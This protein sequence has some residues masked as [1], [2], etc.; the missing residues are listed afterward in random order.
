MLLSNRISAVALL[1]IGLMV[2]SSAGAASISATSNLA[3]NTL[4]A[5]T[6]T[7]HVDVTG[8]SGGVAG[9]A[10]YLVTTGGVQIT[11]NAACVV[12]DCT[13]STQAPL[14]NQ[15]PA[16]L[17]FATAANVQLSNFTLGTLGVTVTGSGTVS[18]AANPPGAITD[19]DLNDFPIQPGALLT[20]TVVVP[21]P[22]TLLLLSS[23]LLGLALV[24]RRRN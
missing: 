22:S 13:S 15:G 5:Q 21:E 20:W 19:N 2:G 16:S 23:G 18:V 14:P 24:G 12:V 7:F 10:L 17:L 8:A 3:P 4:G 1:A 9:V 11:G 6:I